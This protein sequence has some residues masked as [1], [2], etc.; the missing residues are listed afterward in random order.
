MTLNNPYQISRGRHYSTLNISETIQDRD[1]FSLIYAY[2]SKTVVF[3]GINLYRLV[4]LGPCTKK[5]RK[6]S[7]MLFYC[8]AMPAASAALAV[9]RCPCV[10]VC[11]CHVRTFCQND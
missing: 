11:V 8:R 5:S 9:T 2:I 6:Y 10:S 4:C 3:S 1:D 7:Q